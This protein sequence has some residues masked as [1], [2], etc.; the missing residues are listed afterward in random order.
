M[1][2]AGRLLVAAFDLCWLTRRVLDWTYRKEWGACDAV[3][4]IGDNIWSVPGSW[5]C[6]VVGHI[7]CLVLAVRVF[8]SSPIS[9]LPVVI[10]TVVYGKVYG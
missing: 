5:S 10:I 3:L 8:W 7:E 1:I 2:A 9:K 4:G 6:D